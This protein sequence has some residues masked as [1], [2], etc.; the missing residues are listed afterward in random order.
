MNKLNF[1][2]MTRDELAHFMVAHRDTSEEIE[3]RRVYIRRMLEKAN[4]HGINLS[5]PID[6]NCSSYEY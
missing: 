2:T 4:N 6:N 3:A 5:K 1:D